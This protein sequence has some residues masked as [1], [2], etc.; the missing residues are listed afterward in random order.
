M[1]ST[2]FTDWVRV[3]LPLILGV[4][5]G[6]FAARYPTLLTRIC[7][8]LTVSTILLWMALLVTGIARQPEGSL[9]EVHRWCAHLFVIALWIAAPVSI[10]VLLRVR[11]VQHR[12]STLG[13]CLVALAALALGFVAGFTGYL[14]PSHTNTESEPGDLARFQVIHLIAL[15]AITGL[16]L[17]VWAYGLRQKSLA[18]TRS[19]EPRQ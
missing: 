8:A 13:Y 17:G 11:L 12:V 1:E 5:A 9:A 3:L 7:F 15:P 4:G 10:A 14:G 2:E 18:A 6:V 19:T 16:L